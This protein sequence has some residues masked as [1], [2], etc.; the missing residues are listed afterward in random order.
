MVARMMKA[1]L[2]HLLRTRWAS[3]GRHAKPVKFTTS[4]LSRVA[5]NALPELWQELKPYSD[6]PALFLALYAEFH[7]I[8]VARLAES[9]QA[10]TIASHLG[11][12]PYD[13]RRELF[14]RAAGGSNALF[15]EAARRFTG[16]ELREITLTPNAQRDLERLRDDPTALE[17]YLTP[18]ALAE[19][20]QRLA[21]DAY[22]SVTELLGGGDAPA[23]SVT[24]QTGEWRPRGEQRTALARHARTGVTLHHAEIAAALGAHPTPETIDLVVSQTLR[25]EFAHEHL[26]ARAPDRGDDTEMLALVESMAEY[27]ATRG[28]TAPPLRGEISAAPLVRDDEPGASE[29]VLLA[30]AFARLGLPA[31][32]PSPASAVGTTVSTGRSPS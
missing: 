27:A 12:Y 15:V 6:D 18:G 17:G 28:G 16:Y 21:P 4:A 25:H 14:E 31:T 24:V 5:L 29:G 23:P 13:Q 7:E 19:S 11:I 1:G 2:T 20:A 32:A 10:N 22:Q 9:E 30:W 3:G 26:E 8:P